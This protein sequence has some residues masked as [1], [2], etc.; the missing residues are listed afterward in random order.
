M[1]LLTG[2]WN[3]TQVVG[4]IEEATFGTTPVASPA[5]I[6]AGPIQDMS[7][8]TDIN[9]LDYRQIGDRDIQSM[10]KT[11]EAYSFSLKFFP[12]TTALMKYGINLPAGIGTIEKSLSFI[13]AQK[14]DNVVMWTLYKGSR[15]NSIDVEVAMDGAV[16]VT[17][18]FLCA[19]ITTPAASNGL[20]TPTFGA[21]GAGQPMTNI[22]GG[23]SPFT[24]DGTPHDVARLKFSVTQNLQ[25]VK[26]NGEL[27]AKFIEPTNREVTI[28][29]D[30]WLTAVADMTTAKSLTVKQ[31]T[32]TLNATGPITATF[33]DIY[34]NAFNTADSPTAN[35]TKMISYSG[36]AKGVAVT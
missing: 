29:F 33:T 8:N 25:V 14:I 7:E 18:N 31:G 30:T 22:S 13:K 15:C 32:Y 4:Y 5:F 6:W 9:S 34:L 2:H 17:M 11:G 26:P 19:D 3:T 24:F 16:E 28:D 10:I 23:S 35:E 1:V 27:K 12:L 20:T 36:R 21:A